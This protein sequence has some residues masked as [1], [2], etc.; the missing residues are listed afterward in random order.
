MGI[1]AY[2]VVPKGHAPRA[3]VTGIDDKAVVLVPIG[4]VAL[5]VSRLARPVP[6]GQA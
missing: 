1:Y 2:C 6:A 5:W 4:D 3:G